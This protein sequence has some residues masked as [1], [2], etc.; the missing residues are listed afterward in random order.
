MQASITN[1]HTAALQLGGV[2]PRQRLISQRRRRGHQ[3]L[4][5]LIIAAV[6]KGRAVIGR[7]VAATGTTNY[8]ISRS[9]SAQRGQR[10][11]EIWSTPASRHGIGPRIRTQTGR[12]HSVAIGL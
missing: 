2:C 6:S 8:A 9:P 1:R 12:R 10:R 4:P 3:I 7:A 5:R 11:P